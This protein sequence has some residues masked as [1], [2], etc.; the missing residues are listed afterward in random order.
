MYEV[1]ISKDIAKVKADIRQNRQT[2]QQDK[3]NMSLIIP[4]RGITI[5]WLKIY[6]FFLTITH[7]VSVKYLI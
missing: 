4:S 1:S 3:N 7:V 5:H 6:Q 2:N